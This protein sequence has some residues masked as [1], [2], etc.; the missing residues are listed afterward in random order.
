M[1]G[2]ILRRSENFRL[3][4]SHGER[5]GSPLR[6]GPYSRRFAPTR[7]NLPPRRGRRLTRALARAAGEPG[8][9]APPDPP[10]PGPPPPG[11]RRL[12]RLLRAGRLTRAARGRLQGEDVRVTVAAARVP[13]TVPRGQTPSPLSSWS[14][15]SSAEAAAA[16]PDRDAFESIGAVATAILAVC[17]GGR[18][19]AESDGAA[20]GLSAE[21]QNERRRRRRGGT[22]EP[23]QTR[24]CGIDSTS[25]GPAEVG[26]HH[27][28]G[29]SSPR[30]A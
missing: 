9:A 28:G 26:R 1:Y 12:R 22:S 11:S 13:A 5:R 14:G 7:V 16:E 27:V 25:A 6:F 2:W 24:A 18:G 19:G 21:R 29:C 30:Q 3:S 20:R 23:T 4:D 15:Q 10:P 8:A 17:R